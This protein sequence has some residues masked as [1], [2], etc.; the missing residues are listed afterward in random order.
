MVN[1]DIKNEEI[2]EIVD[3][4]HTSKVNFR[5]L[6]RDFIHKMPLEVLEKVFDF[7]VVEPNDAAWEKIKD[8]STPPDVVSR[9]KYLMQ[10]RLYEYK[11][12]LKNLW[13]KNYQTDQIKELNDGD[14][15]I[16]KFKKEYSYVY[17]F[18][19]VVLFEGATKR[20][21]VPE[22]GESLPVEYINWWIKL[23]V[24]ADEE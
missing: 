21:Y 6:L 8:P 10:F 4:D 23:N 16:I 17:I 9:L 5:L 1:I 18:P 7:E 19:M 24:K 12:K 13:I 3:S 22:V 15:V 2:T 11:V 14:L 20:V